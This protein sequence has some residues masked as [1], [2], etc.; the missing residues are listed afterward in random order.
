MPT[1]PGDAFVLEV[2]EEEEEETTEAEFVGEGFYG[3]SDIVITTV[4]DYNFMQDWEFSSEEVTTDNYIFDYLADGA[5]GIVYDEEG[6]Y[7]IYHAVFEHDEPAFSNPEVDASGDAFT[8]NATLDSEEEAGLKELYG[9]PDDDFKTTLNSLVA[10]IA[11]EVSLAT[12]DAAH[13]F[14]N[15]KNPGFNDEMFDAFEVEEGAETVSVS[16]T[17]TY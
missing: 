4:D 3:F 5:V 14:K 1:R 6:S 10:S 8:F 12:A 17:Y 7:K 11:E 15:V 13:T 16:T 2:T 9:P